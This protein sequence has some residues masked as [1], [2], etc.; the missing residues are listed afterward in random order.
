MIDNR[1]YYRQ[2]AQAF[3]GRTVHE[4]VA[5]LYASFLPRLPKGAHILD[6][7]CGSGRDTKAFVERGYR[8]TAIDA[9]PEMAALAEK[10][11][12]QPVRVLRFQELDY[13]AAFDG[14]WA[15]ASLLHVP[16]VELPMV[17]ER[18]I[19]AL[20]PGGYWNMSFKYGE[21]EKR[22]GIR[23]FTDF[24]ETSLSAFLAEFD[25]LKVL[26]VFASGDTRTDRPEQERWVSAVVQKV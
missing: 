2:N 22:R 15:C 17:F 6:A 3:F 8:V 25:T 9:T 12:G 19:L 7:G 24:T 5:T 16:L 14:I 21:G 23:Q 1:E 4:D 10:F 11:T 13:V 20:K 18:F 26:D